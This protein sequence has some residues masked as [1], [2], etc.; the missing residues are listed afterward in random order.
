[1]STTLILQWVPLVLV[2]VA[3]HF[4]LT[5]VWNKESSLQR[6]F[7]RRSQST[8]SD[9][10]MWSLYYVLW[11]YVGAVLGLLV[12]PGIALFAVKWLAQT[13]QWHGLFDG[14]LRQHPFLSALVWLILIDLAAYLAHMMMHKI[15]FLWRFHRV[16]HAATEMNIITGARISLAEHFLYDLVIFMLVAAVVGLPAPEV[17]FVVLFIRRFVDLVQH[18]DL[19]ISYGI[20]GYLIASPRFHRMH[21][22]AE[23]SDRDSNYGNIF[24]VFDYAFGTVARRY[25]QSPAN[26]DAC[27]L[28]LETT[29]ETREMN[30]WFVGLFSETVI[31]Y[32][33]IG[34]HWVGSLFGKSAPIQVEV[35]PPRTPEPS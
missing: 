19:P 25:A 22:S 23:R 8:K 5:R 7:L 15:P 33:I 18:S 1:M 16:H 20:F 3:E 9:L 24:S 2:L 28:G 32:I 4:A 29:S 17:A 27:P 21:H 13:V 12:A 31:H 6:L 26:A 35:K 10:A 14:V 30:N 34:A 11:P